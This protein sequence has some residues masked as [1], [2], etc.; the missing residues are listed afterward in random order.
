MTAQITSETYALLIFEPHDIS[1]RPFPLADMPLRYKY[2]FNVD[3][4]LVTQILYSISPIFTENACFIQDKSYY[5][6]EALPVL[7]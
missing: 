5:T 6:S 3:F 2:A 1:I 7:D 4:A